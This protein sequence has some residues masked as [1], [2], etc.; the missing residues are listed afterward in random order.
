MARTGRFGRLPRS[1][2]SLTATLIAIAREMQAQRDENI[3]NAWQKGG[4]FGGQKVTDDRILAYWRE[5]LDGI[6][7]DDP[8][9]DTYRN[10]IQQY[11]YAISESKM[12]AKYAM[13]ARPSA[14]DDR[15]MAQ[16]YLNWAK[17]V[18]KDSEFYRVLQRDAGQFLRSAASKRAAAQRDNSERAYRTRLAAIEKKHERAG[19]LALTVVTMLA[20]RGVGGRDAVLGEQP[21][22]HFSEIAGRTNIADLQLPAVDEMMSHLA[23]VNMTEFVGRPGPFGSG[24]KRTVGNPSVLYH[25]EAGNPVTGADIIAMLKG[26]DP[27]FDGTLDIASVQRMIA[28]QKQGLQQRIDLARKT[29]HITDMHSLETQ[30][31]RVNEYGNEIAAWPVLE[32]YQEYKM[33]LDRVMLDS[34][35]LPAAKVAAIDRI[36]TNIGNLADDPRIA[37]DDHLRSQLRGEAEGAAGTLT[38]SEDME[39]LR[40]G[41]QTGMDP[42]N[43]EVM[44]INAIRDLLAE[45][46][47]LTRNPAAGYVMTQGDYVPDGKGGQ[48]FQPSPGGQAVGAALLTDVYNLPGAGP[49]VTVMVPNGDGGGA[50]P[51]VMVPAPVF[52]TARKADGT[53]INIT[54][55]NPVATFIKFNVNGQQV[56]VYGL[57]DQATGQVRWTNDPPWDATR[58]KSQEGP[59]GITLDLTAVVPT[60]DTTGPTGGDLGNGFLIIGKDPL[61]QTPGE[62]VMNPAAAA[63]GTQPERQAAGF[64]P[65]TDSFSPTLIALRSTPDGTQ[66]LKQYAGDPTFAK[67]IDDDA[68]RSAGMTY[69]L[70]TGVWNGTAE[71]TRLYEK[72]HGQAQYELDIAKNGKPVSVPDVSQRDAWWRDTTNTQ[73]LGAAPHGALAPLATDV[74]RASDDT[75]FK[76]L[77]N[78]VKPGSTAILDS[79]QPDRVGAPAISTSMKLTVPDFS[80]V[81]PAP[82]P[83]PA[84]APQTTQTYNTQQQTYNTQQQSTSP[85]TDSFVQ[86]MS[87]QQEY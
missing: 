71:Q 28:E 9:Y 50:T 74:L 60:Q 44:N 23:S 51:M 25:D 26:A 39:G 37:A 49:A 31:A 36:R 3:M 19:Q 86:K 40:N 24:E 8:L 57:T 73:T 17:K 64:D 35:L 4:M 80:P 46:I 84:P 79:G 10:A 27:T 22:G 69:D 45:Q 20:Q 75:R 47:E 76:Y 18:P 63:L 1:Q 33:E 53:N 85:L 7:K 11:Q 34:T 14:A 21:L 78:A 82:T 87:R 6:S 5:R 77:Y 67:I 12:T 58:V 43:N 13:I 68:R 38:V 29:G 42:A 56:T 54:N 15:A 48:R 61:R 30:L 16:F 81:A 65:N 2:P 62:V 72:F 66:L 70:A 59:G 83:A 52:A 55:Q 32:V 41:F